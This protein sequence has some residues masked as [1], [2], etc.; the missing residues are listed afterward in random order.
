MAASDL[1]AT[2]D[3]IAPE[4]VVQ[5]YDDYRIRILAGD[6]C[7][8]G[9]PNGK[10]RIP[11]DLLVSVEDLNAAYDT[12]DQSVTAPSVVQCLPDGT[13]VSFPTGGDRRGCSMAV[14]LGSDGTVYVVPYGFCD[15]VRSGSSIGVKGDLVTTGWADLQSFDVTTGIGFAP[16]KTNKVTLNVSFGTQTASNTPVEY[17]DESVA[18]NTV[19][20]GTYYTTTVVTYTNDSQST[21]EDNLPKTASGSSS[22]RIK[23]ARPYNNSYLSYLRSWCYYYHYKASQY[24][25]PP[26]TYVQIN[27]YSVDAVTGNEGY[28]PT[29]R[30]HNFKKKNGS[31]LDARIIGGFHCLIQTVPA[32]ATMLPSEVFGTK[33]HPLAGHNAGSIL[34]KSVW[35]LNF[36]PSAPD[37]SAMVF[38]D[39]ANSWMDV[40]TDEAHLEWIDGSQ[41]GITSMQKYISKVKPSALDTAYWLTWYE[42]TTA[43]A[44]EGKRLPTHDEFYAAAL[45]SNVG[46]VRDYKDPDLERGIASVFD[47][48]VR[49]AFDG[50]GN[51]MVSNLGCEDMCGFLW[52]PLSN[53][54]TFA[55]SSTGQIAANN[56]T[57][58]FCGQNTMGKSMGIEY[59]VAGGAYTTSPA[60]LAAVGPLCRAGRYFAGSTEPPKDMA[61]RGCCGTAYSF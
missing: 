4:P 47:E 56:T 11:Y 7:V 27:D 6:Y 8:E 1:P 34:P 49:K 15:H 55:S 10:V 3:V 22:K 51:R 26:N 50:S 25:L 44:N 45:G 24:G 40:Y 60:D 23:Y 2:L 39:F 43:L 14:A 53:Y 20:T 35:A 52:Q 19:L 54:G 37:P 61:P 9:A 5:Y 32:N 16:G 33:L 21:I 36:S 18:N 42:V 30:I 31:Y 46:T 41:T 58:S 12:D 29:G 28:I 48:G 17:D 38:I 59:V 13:V 57:L